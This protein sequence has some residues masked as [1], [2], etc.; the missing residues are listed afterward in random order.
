MQKLK[1]FVLIVSIIWGYPTMA[2]WQYRAQMPT[3]RAGITAVTMNDRIS[4]NSRSTVYPLI[5]VR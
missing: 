1:I 5:E 4:G 2:Q 3:T